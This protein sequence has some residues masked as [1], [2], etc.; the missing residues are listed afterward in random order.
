M[1]LIN[2]IGFTD[3]NMVYAVTTGPAIE[4]ITVDE[5]KDFARIDGTD[6]DTLITAFIK[7]AR[8]QTENYLNRALITQT[9]TVSMD[10][11]PS[12]RLELP[13][14]S[15]QSVTEVRTLEEDG[16][17]TVYDADNYYT[18][19][20]GIKGE[21]ILKIGSTPPQSLN[22]TVGGIEIDLVAGYG[23]ASTDIPQLIVEGLKLWANVIYEKRVIDDKPPPEA[24]AMLQ[25]FRVNNV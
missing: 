14:P 23:D 5:L 17:A 9:V 18:R 7:A 22:R 24:A 11:W 25:L 12:T 13:F 19:I 15:M 1:S 21:I 10:F 8:I 20:L 6:E 16:T 3:G 2:D 4:P